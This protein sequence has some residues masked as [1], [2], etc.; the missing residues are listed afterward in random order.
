MPGSSPVLALRW[1]TRVLISVDLPTFGIPQINTRTGLTMPPRPGTRARQAATST[2]AGAATVASSASACVPGSVRRWASHSSVIAGS[3]R[4][5]LLS[6]FSAGL[7]A[8]SSASS[9]LALEPGSRASSSS[10]TTSMPGKRAASALRVACMCPGNHWM[11]MAPSVSRSVA[12]AS[13]RRRRFRPAW[14]RLPAPPR[15]SDPGLRERRCR[16][17]VCRPAAPGRGRTAAPHRGS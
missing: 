5:C 8:V 12:A 6:T 16:P 14:R 9:G 1:P 17:A 3:A 2:R 15:R 7:P 11:A 13:A 4:S 10:M